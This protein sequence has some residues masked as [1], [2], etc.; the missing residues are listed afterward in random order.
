MIKSKVA[1]VCAA[2]SLVSGFAFAEAEY[3]FSNK[4][5]SDIVNIEKDGDED[6]DSDF[7][8]IKNKT[9]FEFSSEKV[10]ALLEL[11]FWSAKAKDP[12]AEDDDKYFAV[13]LTSSDGTDYGY[14]FGDSYIEVRPFDI[15]GLEFHE[16]VFTAGSYLPVWD[17]NV[18][19]GN[20]ASDFGLLVRPI[21]GL[22]IGGG[23][24]FVSVFGHDDY[25][26]VVNFGAEYSADA[27][28]VGAA[29]RDVADNDKLDNTDGFTFG[30]Y[31][32]LLSVENLVLNAGFAYNDSVGPDVGDVSGKLLTLGAT[33]ELDAFHSALDF[34]TN[35]ADSDDEEFDFYIAVSAG[36]NVVETLSL[37]CAFATALD[38]ESDSDKKADAR[39]QINPS[40]TYGVGNHEFSAGVNFIFGEDYTS[41]NFPVYW[42][43][44]F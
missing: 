23:L 1:A 6:T 44:S 22:V 40:A 18:A 35:F 41:V 11:T 17:D 31:A 36:Y 34:A 38:A 26:P 8:G 32:S 29:V 21:E 2:F 30:V 12:K 20:I 39:F 13:G 10:D 3:S 19:S 37:D 16:K 5:S 9:S 15:L 43:Y 24:D 14:D 7:A 28:A 4:L 27:F 33:Y 42:K 25:K